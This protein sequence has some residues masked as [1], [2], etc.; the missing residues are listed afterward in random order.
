MDFYTI[1]YPAAAF[2]S[3][4]IPWSYII[5]RMRG[6]DIRRSGSGNV[7][8]TNLFRT[9][10]RAAGITGLLLDALKGALPVLA[11]QR[12]ILGLTPSAGDWV[13]ASAGICAVLGH[14]FSPWLGFRGGKGVATTM[15]VLLFLAP[16]SVLTGLAVFTLVVLVFR[17]VSLGSMLAALTMVPAVFVFQP[18]SLP[19]QLV[20]CLAAAIILA[21]HRSNLAKLLRGQENRFSLGGGGDE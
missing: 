16:L 4:S 6:L 13:L 15:G 11:A 1:A 2:L 18:G 3:G 20:I 5:G 7:G 19:V 17:Y 8:A 21:R 14:V 12:G 10:G 9:C